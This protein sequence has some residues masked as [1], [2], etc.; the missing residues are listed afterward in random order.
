M[1]KKW[2]LN[3]AEKVKTGFWS[4]SLAKISKLFFYL[5]IL[6]LPTQLGKHFWPNFSFVYGLRLDYLSP[7][8]YFTD[9][10]I[11]LIFISSVPK[12]FNA[13]A[14]VKRKYFLYFILVV[15]FLFLGL[16]DAKNFWAGTYGIVKFLEYSFLIYFIR[17]NYKQFNKIFLF[18]C[19][20]TSIIFESLL[21]F[22]QYFNQGSLGGI[23]Y[24]FGERTFNTLTPGIA[25]ASING[26]LFLRPYATFSHPNVLA[27]FLIASM[28]LLLMFSAKN[29]ILK[30]S[31]SVGIIMGT[32]AL[33]LTLSRSA[34]LVW[35]ISL[36]ILFGL[37]LVEK[38]KKGKFNS[39]NIALPILI[40]F[41]VGAFLFLQ[42]NYIFQRFLTT[43][44]SDQSITQ[45]QELMTQSLIM[46]WNN[47]VMGVGVNNYFDNLI[48]ATSQQKDYL[49][50]PVHNIF[51]LIMSETGIIGLFALSVIFAKS[52]IES[53]KNKQNKKYLLLLIFSMIFLGMFDHYLLTLQQGQL[54]LSLV[55]GIALAKV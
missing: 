8:F 26:Q 20:L 28:L 49:L 34:I 50:Q 41:I 29:R 2:F 16:T 45:R 18:V 33:L 51:L 21:A 12:L 39:F 31:A 14:N 52:I 13:L 23:L 30:I 19:V 27:G 1:I 17:Q 5:L 37:S 6:F 11:L 9:L 44:L 24:V 3:Q 10:L 25:D 36:C 35:L 22:L 15:G 7:T 43:N 4:L 47:P 32:A 40:V 55:F 48:I 54:L 53:F 46:F 42:N 38:Y